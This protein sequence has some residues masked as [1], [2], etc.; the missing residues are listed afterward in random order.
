M[1]RLG[2][3]G[4]YSVAELQDAGS[5][6]VEDGNHGEYRPLPHEFSLIG[7][8]FI[9]ATDLGAGNVQFGSASRINGTARARIRK[10]IGAGGDVILSHKGTVGKIA[11][12]PLDCEPFVCSPQTTFWRSLDQGAIDRRYL[13]YYLCSDDFRRQLDARKGE[14]DMA[15]Y[16]SLTA[17]RE[18]RVCLPPIEEQRSI[19]CILGGLDDKIELNRRMNQTLESMA[20][21]IFRSWFVDFDPVVAKAA[22]RQPFGMSAEVAALFRSHFQGSPLGPIPRGWK[23]EPI[24]EVVSCVG[25]ATPS[26]TE[27]KFWDGGTHHWATPRDFA[28]LQSPI[29]LDTERKITDAGVARI[30]S[31]LLPAGTLLLSSRAPIGYLAIAAMP[32]A[33]NQGF[34]ALK[35]NERASNFFLLNWCQTNM[36]EIEGRATGTTFAEISKQ[37]FRPILLAVPPKDLMT[38]FTSNVAA[39]YHRITTNL[40]QSRTLAALRDTLLP[41]LMS[42]ELRVRDAEKLA[43]SHV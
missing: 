32:V 15:D 10:G 37:N 34:I 30:S 24:G 22:G 39:L 11:F 43:G 42:G 16:V 25:G 23:V 19:G 17:Q 38:I 1:S 4:Q 31:G 13:Y 9:R 2:K 33:I 41:K 36:A 35:C 7:V 28:S 8:S 21:A 18:L 5:L 20:R 40:R 3:W 12:A 14:T 6:L 26:T 27:P 29:L